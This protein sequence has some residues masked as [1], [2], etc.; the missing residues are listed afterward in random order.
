MLDFETEMMKK[1]FYRERQGFSFLDEMKFVSKKN[2]STPK[3]A[4]KLN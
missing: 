3:A 4:K 2:I 1:E